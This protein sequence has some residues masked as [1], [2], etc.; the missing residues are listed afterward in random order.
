M[1]AVMAA[2]SRKRAVAVIALALSFG[3]VV[4]VGEVRG[5]YVEGSSGP[6]ETDAEPRVVHLVRASHTPDPEPAEFSMQIEIKP[7]K[8]TSEDPQT[9]LILHGWRL[10]PED[11]SEWQHE[12][13][14]DGTFCR[15]D[16]PAGAPLL[17][18]EVRS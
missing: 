7:A 14:P 9:C 6:G 8:H 15:D 13:Q 10:S 12:R 1:E 2:A 17:V 11:L 5:P 4:A 3:A 16:L 18:R